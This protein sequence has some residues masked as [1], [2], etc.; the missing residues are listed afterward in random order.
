MALLILYILFSLLIDE[1]S[2]SIALLKILG[3][4]VREIRTLMSAS[5]TRPFCC[6]FLAG[7]PLLF[8]FMAA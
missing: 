6:G 4:E 5:S 2:R 3:Y 7:I 8:E 1:N